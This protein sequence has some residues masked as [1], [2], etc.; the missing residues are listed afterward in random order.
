MALTVGTD[1]YISQADATTYISNNYTT[2]SQEYTTWNALSSNDKDLY[3]RKACK[4]LDR[5]ILR[6]IKALATQTLEFPRAIRTDYYNTNYPNTALRFTSDWVVE[7]SVTQAVKESQVEEAI[8]IAT[9]GVQANK[10]IELQNQGVKSFSLGNLSENYG[11]G[12][13]AGVTKLLST[14]AIELLKYYLCGSVDIV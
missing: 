10:R 4:K 2:T 11:N 7:Q 13:K 6:G 8:T 14:N 5:Q 12:I 9:Y 1:T 3:L